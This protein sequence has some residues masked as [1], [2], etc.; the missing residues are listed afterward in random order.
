MGPINT[1]GLPQREIGITAQ[2][3]SRESRH[4]VLCMYSLILLLGHWIKVPFMVSSIT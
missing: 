4:I 3:N 2:S 1:V